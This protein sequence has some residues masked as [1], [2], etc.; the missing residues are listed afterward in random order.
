MVRYTKLQKIKNGAVTT[1]VP[2]QVVETL[3]LEKG[4]FLLWEVNEQTIIITIKK[5]E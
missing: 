2:K 4:D 1:S 3:S 5:K